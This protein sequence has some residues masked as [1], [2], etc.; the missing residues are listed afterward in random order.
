MK[1]L[2]S[3]LMTLGLLSA[4]NAADEKAPFQG[5]IEA[6][7][8]NTA[9][10]TDSQDVAGNVK[11]KYA[12]EQSDLRFVGN[13]LYSD[14]TQ[15]DENG[16]F[17]DDLRTKN[18]WDAEANYDY[19]FNDTWAFNYLLG[20]KGDEFS[21]FVYQAYTGPGAIWTPLKTDAQSLKFQLNVLYSWDRIREDKTATPPVDEYTNDYAGYQASLDYVFKFTK[22]SKFIQYAM[23][24]SEFSDTSNYFIKSKTAVESKLSDIFSLG[25]SYTLDYTNNKADNVRSYT[26]GVF[27]ASIIADF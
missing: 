14:T 26:D 25:V 27:L 13:V 11:L 17:I 20:G 7:Y 5:H 6:S 24:R 22:T 10:N 16:T 19:N 21:T 18:R 9:G 23:Y 4:V 3:I 2:V 1:K 12:F 8:A 15:Y